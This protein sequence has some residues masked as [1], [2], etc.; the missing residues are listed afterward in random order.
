M[1][2]FFT[3]FIGKFK[4]F[5][6]D[7]L[8]KILKGTQFTSNVFAEWTH[9]HVD[10]DIKYLLLIYSRVID[11]EYSFVIWLYYATMVIINKH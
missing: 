7:M 10:L 1:Q 8:N 5:A 4:A 9:V 6:I 11:A 2:C 3:V